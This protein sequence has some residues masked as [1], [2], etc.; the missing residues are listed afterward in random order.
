MCLNI[1]SKKCSNKEHAFRKNMK[2]FKSME[3]PTVNSKFKLIIYAWIL[4]ISNA[5]KTKTTF[6]AKLKMQIRY[7]NKNNSIIRYIFRHKP[8]LKQTIC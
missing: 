6:Y 7:F 3:I 1:N 2:T 5:L 4:E 8:F